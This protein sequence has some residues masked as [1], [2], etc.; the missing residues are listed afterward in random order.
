LNCTASKDRITPSVSA[1]K[2]RREDI[3]AG[4]VGMVVGS[5]RNQLHELL[6]RF[7]GKS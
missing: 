7:L 6:A 1:P 5:A 2:G 4:H 3:P